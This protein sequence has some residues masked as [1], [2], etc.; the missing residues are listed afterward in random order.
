MNMHVPVNARL[1]RAGRLATDVDPSMNAIDLAIERS[2]VG[3]QRLGVAAPAI[4][5]LVGAGRVPLI[6]AHAIN[7]SPREN[8]RPAERG[9]GG[10][11]RRVRGAN[12]APKT[13]F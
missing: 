11:K 5:K 2:S 3:V 1:V 13:L 7:I 9:E 6:I 10:A 12:T 8:P 4:D